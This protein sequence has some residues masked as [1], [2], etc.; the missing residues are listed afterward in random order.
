MIAAC[1][2]G[3]PTDSGDGGGG[4]S[5]SGG[6]ASGGTSG[7]SASGGDSAGGSSTGGSAS[8]GGAGSGGEAASGGSASGGSASGGG[9]SGGSG[10]TPPLPSGTCGVVRRIALPG[11]PLGHISGDFGN[12]AKPALV[13]RVLGK[14]VVGPWGVTEGDDR[15]EWLWV[16]DDGVQQDP[17][18]LA[19]GTPSLGYTPSGFVFAT[20]EARHITII[21]GSSMGYMGGYVEEDETTYTWTGALLE[22][23]FNELFISALAG[24]SL[25]GQRGLI[26]AGFSEYEL[27]TFE[28][29]GTRVGDAHLLALTDSCWRHLPTAQGNALLHGVQLTELSASGEIVLDHEVSPFW[30]GTCPPAALTEDGFAVLNLEEDATW[31]IHRVGHDGSSTDEA[32][33]AIQSPPLGLAVWDDFSLVLG[34]NVLLRFTGDTSEEFELTEITPWARVIPAEPGKLFLDLSV[35]NATTREIIELGCAE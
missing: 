14:F 33:P 30:D 4:G 1:S 18:S 26:V 9:P 27:A 10:G 16:S 25:D 28:P 11:A 17:Y 29:G 8:D 5:A 19:V 7:G 23:D 22:T 13:R 32:W 34:E 6:A 24:I 21:A 15:S 12:D 31:H 20:S 35:P 2:G 3:A